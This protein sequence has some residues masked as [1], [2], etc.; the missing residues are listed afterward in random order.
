MGTSASFRAPATPRWQAFTVALQEG[1]AAERVQSEM[2]NAGAEWERALSGP[3]V[4]AFAQAVAAAA[5]Q[6]GDR[7][8]NVERPESALR[9]YIADARAQSLA[10]AATPA[11]A[12]AERSMAAVLARAAGAEVIEG[13]EPERVEAAIRSSFAEPREAVGAYLGE[14]L[15][16]YAR[17]VVSRET[18]RL[19]EGER[20]VG[21]AEVRARIRDLSRRAQEIGESVPVTV[22]VRGVNEAWPALVREAFRRGR[23]LPEGHE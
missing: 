22:D 9:E 3:A 8:Q 4:A 23:E 15:G 12:L 10:A 19:T 14:L 21:V 16:Q 18:G 17:H 11:L 1:L 20:G 5:G 2:F 7:L 6:L 13:G